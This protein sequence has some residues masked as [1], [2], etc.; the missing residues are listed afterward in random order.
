MTTHEKPVSGITTA[1]ELVEPYSKHN[2]EKLIVREAQK[3]PKQYKW[4][5]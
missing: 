2:Y 3:K 5:R 1:S 4:K